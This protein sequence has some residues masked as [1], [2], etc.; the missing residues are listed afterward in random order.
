MKIINELN[1]VKNIF[2]KNYFLVLPEEK[3]GKVYIKYGLINQ[4]ISYSNFL[5]IIENYQINQGYIN[6]NLIWVEDNEELFL[7]SEEDKRYKNSLI[8]KKYLEPGEKVTFYHG[9]KLI[10]GVYLTK[11]YV[12]DI[13]YYNESMTELKKRRYY[14]LVDEVMQN[15]NSN[16]DIMTVNGFDSRYMNEEKNLYDLRSIWV[17]HGIFIS[18]LSKNIKN[19][20]ESFLNKYISKFNKERKI[21]IFYKHNTFL[22]YI[23]NNMFEVSSKEGLSHGKEKLTLYN[24]RDFKEVYE[25]IDYEEDFEGY[26]VKERRERREKKE[27]NNNIINKLVGTDNKATYF[28]TNEEFEYVEVKKFGGAVRYRIVDLEKKPETVVHMSSY[29]AEEVKEKL[30]NAG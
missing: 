19:E 16:I 13:D 15:F 22:A 30:I 24:I 8:D 7:I 20:I 12:N 9:K 26:K 10:S 5:E 29:S 6:K 14:I 25:Y 11:G 4:E 23:G 18:T 2:R 1:E 17:K 27:L 3:E 28:S 21:T